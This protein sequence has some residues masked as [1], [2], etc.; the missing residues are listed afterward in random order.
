A[1]STAGPAGIT[2]V[3]APRRPIGRE[4]YGRGGRR[5]DPPTGRGGAVQ[6][7]VNVLGLVKGAG[8]YVFVGG[9][10]TRGPLLD[11]FRKPAADPALSLN[12]FDAAVLTDKARE[13][14]RFAPPD[15][16]PARSRI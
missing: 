8:R 13:Q 9:G 16:W 1:P 14:F 11:A 2:K 6:R 10:A 12:W 15:G 4:A 5:P 7:E 3:A